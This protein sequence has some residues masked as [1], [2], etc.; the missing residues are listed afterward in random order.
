[1]TPPDPHGP[2][3]DGAGLGVNCE[4]RGAACAPDP[5]DFA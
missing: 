3:Y 1:M 2:G 4:E 5:E